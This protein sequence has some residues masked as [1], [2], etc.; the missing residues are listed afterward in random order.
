MNILKILGQTMVWARN[1]TLFSDKPMSENTNIILQRA[2]VISGKSETSQGA[3]SSGRGPR[4]P[5]QKE[6]DIAAVD[7]QHQ[8]SATQD[9]SK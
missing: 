2:T 5:L 6:M 1:I 7:F 3:Q 8:W 9:R 4:T